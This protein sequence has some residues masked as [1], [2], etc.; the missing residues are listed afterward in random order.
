MGVISFSDNSEGTWCVAGWAFRQ[1]LDDVARLYAAHTELVDK[2]EQAKLH[3]GLILYL[4][5]VSFAERI[6]QAIRK[7]ANGI[8]AGNIQS[9]ISEQP[10]GDVIT[11][12]QYRESLKELL[13]ILSASNGLREDHR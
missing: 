5:E 8:L 4:L 11:I 1:I 10:Y 13:R 3:S 12:E 7:V 2:F 6:K 9:G